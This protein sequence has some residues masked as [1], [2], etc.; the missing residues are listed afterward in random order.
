MTN[1]SIISTSPLLFVDVE[2][3]ISDF[4]PIIYES[5]PPEPTASY[6]SLDGVSNYVELSDG[7]V[8]A[9]SLNLPTES[10]TLE[11]WVKLDSFQQWSSFISFIQD[12][13]STEAGFALGTT[14]DEKFYFALA[15]GGNGITYLYSP[16]SYQ[17]DEW[18]HLAAT[19]DGSIMKLLLDGVEVASSTEQTGAIY[20]LDSWYRIGKYQ[21][22]DENHEINGN[23]DEVRIWDVARTQAEIQQNRDR[24]LTG[25]ELGLTGYWHFNLDSLSG[26]T[27]SDL[28]GNGND[29]ILIGD[30]ELG[31]DSPYVGYVDITLNEPV[32][33]SSGMFLNYQIEGDS[34]TIQ[35]EDA[36]GEP[37]N[38]SPTDGEPLTNTVFIPKN[39]DSARIYFTV[40]PDGII[41][42]NEE[43]SFTLLSTRDK[44]IS[45]GGRGDYLEIDLDE[46]ETEIT[47]ELWFKTIDG[48]AGIFSITDGNLASSDR[49]LYLDKGNIYARVAG[50]EIINS[51]DLNLADGEWHHL[52]HV[53][54][55]SVSGQQLY[56]DGELVASGTLYQS[57][58]T[59]QTQAI[60]QQWC[61]FCIGRKSS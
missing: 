58:F 35:G 33:S 44:A 50:D 18:Y 37:I 41:E 5:S 30:A 16:E 9:S 28:T 36:Q 42:G 34:T 38:I 46:P 3:N 25:S 14:E 4:T 59:S 31:V 52:A 7:K 19:Y 26:N 51:T 1:K 47:H 60:V 11:T 21:D 27:V 6:L 57:S 12:N 55:D 45:L 20:Y 53:I 23:I 49:S 32:S 61:F 54:G 39:K 24:V 56:I 40:L 8:S 29:G 15:G 10:L 2:A 17:T 22:D 48:N 43:I 13:G